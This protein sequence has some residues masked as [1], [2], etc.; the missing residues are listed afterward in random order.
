MEVCEEE[1][2]GFSL[3]AGAAK[4]DF[5]FIPTAF[6]FLL[7]PPPSSC[8]SLIPFSLFWHREKPKDLFFYIFFWSSLDAKQHQGEEEEKLW[9]NKYSLITAGFVFLES[10]N[11]LGLGKDSKNHLIGINS[12]KSSPRV[13]WA[14]SS[15]ARDPGEG[16][17]SGKSIPGK[18]SFPKLKLNFPS[19]FMNQVAFPQQGLLRAVVV[20]TGITQGWILHWLIPF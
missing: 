19:L 4:S 3:N 11:G 9:V 5:F 18:N 1:L 12:T 7:L 6:F 2:R 14:P 8:C 13:L 15:L 17:K 16:W 20:P 10:Q